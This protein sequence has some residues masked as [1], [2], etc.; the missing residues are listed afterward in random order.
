M[1]KV[2][3]LP[4]VCVDHDLEK[5]HIEIEIPGVKKEDIDLEM[6]EASFC[7]RAPKEDIEYSACYTLAHDVDTGKVTAKFDNGLLTI[8]APFKSAIGGTKITV[9]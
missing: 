7:I 3:I 8:N 6:G 4:S 9:E 5:F 2:Q 1:A